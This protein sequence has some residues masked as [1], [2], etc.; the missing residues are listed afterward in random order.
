MKITRLVVTALA[1]TLGLGACGTDQGTSGDAAADPATAEEVGE[2][3][4]GAQGEPVTVRVGYIAAPAPGAHLLL[5]DTR[6]Y[7]EE[8]GITVETTPFTTGISL[9]QALTGGSIDVGVMGAVIANFPAQGQGQVFLLNNLEANIQQLW[10]APDSDI[11]TVADLEGA[12]IATTEG[13]AAHLLLYVALEEEGL[14][15][16]DVEISSLDM[17]SVANTFVT[18]GIEAAALWAPFDRQIEDRLPDAVQLATSGDYEEAGIAGGWVANNDFYAEHA[19][20]LAGITRAW[21]QANA[22]ITEDQDS[23]LAD[24]CPQLEE[25][26]EPDVCEHVY[27]QTENFTNDEWVTMYEDGTATDWV[28][29]MENV[30]VEIGALDES[31]GPEEYF[32]TSIFLEAAGE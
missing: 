20:A 3:D 1:L 30:F 2:A 22:D 23:A 19:D 13:T 5:A 31:V 15:M 6:G 9:S 4:N 11:E 12:E 18:G 26:M 16:D 25:H 14:S 29:R 21:L 28:G 32:D 7:F 17:P 10:A 8:Q 27:A 24:V